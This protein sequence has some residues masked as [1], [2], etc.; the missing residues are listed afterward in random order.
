MQITHIHAYAGPE[1]CNGQD[2]EP[3]EGQLYAISN[4]NVADSKLNHSPVSNKK[5]IFFMKF[6]KMEP[7]LVEDDLIPR[8]KFEL[9]TLGGLH[10]RVGES[11]IL[12]GMEKNFFF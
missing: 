8:H 4:F 11:K 12:T 5:C 1:F 7:I 9:V 3:K 2:A 6:T 10:T